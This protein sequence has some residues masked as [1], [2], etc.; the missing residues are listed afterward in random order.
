MMAPPPI[1]RRETAARATPQGTDP[2]RGRFGEA[3][4]MRKTSDGSRIP[5]S[6][7]EDSNGNIVRQSSP[8]R[9]LGQNGSG[10]IFAAADRPAGR[11]GRPVAG[12]VPGAARGL[13]S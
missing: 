1:V 5:I 3:V 11:R 2:G 7:T 4:D 13:D 12:R 9:G 6:L 8:F 10:T